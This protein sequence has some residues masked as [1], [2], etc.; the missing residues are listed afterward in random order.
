MRSMLR[1]LANLGRA[2][3]RHLPERPYPSDHPWVTHHDPDRPR[4]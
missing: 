4:G 2:F 1:D 3:T